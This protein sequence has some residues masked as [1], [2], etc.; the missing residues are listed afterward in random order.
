MPRVQL[1]RTRQR[2]RFATRDI[3]QVQF[4]N[5]LSGALTEFGI[6]TLAGAMWGI[7]GMRADGYDWDASLNIGATLAPFTGLAA[8][9]IGSV[10]G[11]QKVYQF[12]ATK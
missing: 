11:N 10:I 2:L 9:W 12:S 5:E 8:A 3:H 1:S 7:G 4:R 6:G